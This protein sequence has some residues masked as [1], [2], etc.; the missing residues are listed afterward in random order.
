ASQNLVSYPR[1]RLGSAKYGNELFAELPASALGE[2]L[3]GLGADA[4]SVRRRL[5][6]RL[7]APGDHRFGHRRRRHRVAAEGVQAGDV[8]IAGGARHIG[9]QAEMET[10]AHA[11]T[12]SRQRAAKYGA[13]SS[14]MR[15]VARVARRGSPPG[16]LQASCR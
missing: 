12:S 15:K 10:G 16:T 4:R 9:V 7:P 8:V 1:L 11:L 2:V 5:G 13:C 6:A 14:G 3:R